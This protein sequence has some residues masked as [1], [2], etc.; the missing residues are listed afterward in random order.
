MDE[1]CLKSKEDLISMANMLPYPFMIAES[2]I[3]NV[4]NPSFYLNQNV[5]DEFG[6]SLEEINNLELWYENI[7]PD[8]E[9]R[10]LVIQN[11]LEELEKAKVKNE[12]FVKI[13]AKLKPKDKPVRWYEIKAFFINT[14][15]V[16]S[17]VDIHNEIILNEELRLQNENNNRVLSILGHDLRMPIANLSS[18]SAL[19][20]TNNITKQD[21]VLMAEEIN[22]EAN[23]VLSMLDTTFNWAKLNFDSLQLNFAAINYNNLIEKIITVYQANCSDKK[24][25][26]L[27]NLNGFKTNET[28]EEIVAIILRNLISNAIKFTPTGGQI[29]IYSQNDCLIIEDSGI[30]MSLD[31]IKSIKTNSCTS[32]RGTNNELGIG[33]GLQLVGKLTEKIN[34]KISFESQVGHGTKAFLSFLN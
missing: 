30:G 13:R 3:E 20:L 5:V 27:V 31:K 1:Y 29:S 34:C 24:I 23:Q 11:F 15:F 16:L 6:Y 18:I 22:K 8:I 10:N 28:D 12:K 4:D 17:F 9:Y 32:S 2:N 25:S 14:F 7:Y 26:V 33:L 19:A 21:F